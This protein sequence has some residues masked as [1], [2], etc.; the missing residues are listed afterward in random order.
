MLGGRVQPTNLPLSRDATATG[1]RC[2]EVGADDRTLLDGRASGP[3]RRAFLHGALRSL[4]DALGSLGGRL[5][6][7]GGDPVE[8]V[9]AVARRF[10]ATS[11]WCSQGR[12]P[13][14]PPPRQRRGGALRADGRIG[15]PLVDAGMRQL[16]GRSW[17]HNRARLVVASFL[18]LSRF[19]EASGRR[20]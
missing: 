1:P 9:P 20:P 10:A 11:V 8:V 17:V 5:E 4:A 14:R 7:L 15:Y 12:H 18:A 2:E 6:V 13:L 16:T 19:Q 3:N